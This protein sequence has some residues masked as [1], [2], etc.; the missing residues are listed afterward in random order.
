MAPPRDVAPRRALTIARD[1]VARGFGVIPLHHPA[2][3]SSEMESERHRQ[4][5]GD[6]VET[7]P[8]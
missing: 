5:A 3:V 6:R 1:L 7:L 2:D 4:K 8:V